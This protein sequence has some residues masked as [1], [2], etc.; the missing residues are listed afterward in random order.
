MPVATA[1][2]PAASARPVGPRPAVADGAGAALRCGVVRR[3]GRCRCVLHRRRG[4]VAL[5]RTP[6]CGRRRRRRSSSRRLARLSTASKAPRSRVARHDGAMRPQVAFLFTGQGAQYAGMGRGF[7]R[8]RPLSGARWTN[9]RKGWRL[10]WRSGCWMWFGARS[11]PA[12]SM[13]P[14]T[15]SR[16]CSRSNTHLRRCGG[17]GELNRWRCWATAS[18]NTSQPAWPGCCRSAMRCAWWRSGGG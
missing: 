10:I 4:T 8:R 3:R 5:C 6:R 15:H 7:T 2:A 12:R 9:V 16:R 17:P 18:V 13:V 1:G 11:R 14:I